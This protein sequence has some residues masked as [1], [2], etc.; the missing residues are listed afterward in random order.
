MSLGNKYLFSDREQWGVHCWALGFIRDRAILA[1][2]KNDT[3]QIYTNYKTG[4]IIRK[5][6]FCKF[7][8]GLNVFIVG[9]SEINT[10][11]RGSNIKVLEKNSWVLRFRGRIR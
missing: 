6:G 2:D 7:T 10:E 3:L 9:L 11:F 1:I 8:T 5:T 4:Q